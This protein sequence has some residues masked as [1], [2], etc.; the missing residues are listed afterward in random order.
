MSGDREPCPTC[1]RDLWHIGHA[2]YTY[3]D[4]AASRPALDGDGV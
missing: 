1:D 4:L 3:A 2:C